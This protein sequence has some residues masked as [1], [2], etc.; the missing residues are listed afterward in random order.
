MPRFFDKSS[1]TDAQKANWDAAIVEYKRVQE[2][3]FEHRFARLTDGERDYYRQEYGTTTDQEIRNKMQA[4][5]SLTS[6]SPGH[7]KSALFAR[8]LNGKSA[9]PSPPPTSYSYPWYSVIEEEGPHVVQVGAGA[10][11]GDFMNGAGGGKGPL[12]VSI[13]QC[14]WVVLAANEAAQALLNLQAELA[15]T[16]KPKETDSYEHLFDWSESLRQRVKSAYSAK[17]EFSVQCGCWPA[18]RLFVDQNTDPDKC[19]RSVRYYA[20]S[21][22]D[23]D[24]RHLG[25]VFD[26]DVLKLNARVGKTLGLGAHPQRRLD[27]AR[28]RIAKAKMSSSGQHPFTM[29]FDETAANARLSCLEDDVRAYEADPTSF[30]WVELFIDQ[31]HLQKA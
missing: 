24:L 26:L 23:R 14:C 2:R 29:L 1:L 25:S 10:T 8:L 11:L 7:P 30:D 9:L 31:W 18:Y 3:N 6:N 4:F 13:N 20:I 16:A 22:S 12:A 21:D 19:H 28:D 15:A 17:P 27:E 5:M